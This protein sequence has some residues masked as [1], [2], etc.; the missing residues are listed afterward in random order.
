MYRAKALGRDTLCFF[1]PAM[2]NAVLARVA[3]KSD[4]Q[5]AVQNR[6]FELH[7]QPQVD[8]D[9]HVVG[10]EALL[11]WPHPERGFVPPDEFIPLAEED[12]LI[13]EL[14]RWVLETACGDLARWALDP[15]MNKLK[16]AVNVSLRQLID[17]NFVK[18]VLDVLA[19]SGADPH[20]LKLEITESCVME[21]VN[22]TIAKMTALQA[23]GVGFSLDD[24]G[25]GYASL[26]H[27]KRL[28]LDQLKIDRSFVK[29]VLTDVKDASI[30]RTIITLGHNLG[31]AVIAEG[32]ETQGQCDFLE[33]EG[34][35]SYQGY[36]FSP[37][38]NSVRF[39]AFVAAAPARREAVHA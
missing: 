1:D 10:A 15:K 19:E 30:A 13:V 22:D 25:T 39:A 6:E 35:R 24:F 34:C 29:D 7:Y 12:G 18:L 14:G 5:R 26:S 36:L 20:R 17:S 32:V 8:T 16:I 33:R 28:P 2:R 23:H 31:M 9:G 27:L 21:N 38:L 11:R 4:L 3:L 37:A